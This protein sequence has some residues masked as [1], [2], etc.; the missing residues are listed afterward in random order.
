MELILLLKKDSKY[1]KIV[2][3]KDFFTQKSKQK[4]QG[5]NDV[6]I[7]GHTLEHVEEPELFIKNILSCADTNS[8]IFLQ[9][10]S[11]ESLILSGGFQQIHH[12]HLNY[13]SIKSFG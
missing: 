7:C 10:P 9:F 1:K 3:I 8:K 4:I 2:A 6:I 12:Q 11:A 13:F 5:K